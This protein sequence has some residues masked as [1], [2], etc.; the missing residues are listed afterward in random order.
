MIRIDA[1]WLAT[2]SGTGHANLIF[3]MT[4]QQADSLLIGLASFGE[5]GMHCAPLREFPG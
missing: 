4:P 2:E 3:L 5:V 1:V